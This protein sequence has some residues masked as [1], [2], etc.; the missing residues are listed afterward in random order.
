MELRL[1]SNATT[2]LKVRAYIRDSE[3]SVAEL[4]RELGVSETTIRRWKE[5]ESTADRSHV[6][7]DIR[8]GFDATEEAI[9]LAIRRQVGLSLDDC[10]KVMRRCLREDIS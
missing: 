1:H 5:R 7:H 3:A 10:L 4:S 6:P 8:S 2:T 9:A